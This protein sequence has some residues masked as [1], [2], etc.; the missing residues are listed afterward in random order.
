MVSTR[1]RRYA[2]PAPLKT[3]GVP[4]KALGAPPRW[5]FRMYPWMWII[6]TYMAAALG[7]G[8]VVRV[9][10]N[11]CGVDAWNPATWSNAILTAGS[12]WCRALQTL[13]A[14][15]TYLTEHWALHT[16]GMMMVAIPVSRRTPSPTASALES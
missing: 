7:T 1:R 2:S 16:V 4:Y 10:G 8:S 14:A 12:S 3:V 5:T 9:Y 6:A 11:T 13:S 15:G